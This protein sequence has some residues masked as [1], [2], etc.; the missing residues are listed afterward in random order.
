MTLAFITGN[1]GKL[2]ELQAIIPD[3]TGLDVDLPEIQE[4]DAHK[5]IAAKLEEARKHHDGAL[6]AEDTSLYLNA[7]NG[8][9]GPLIK[10]FL[11]TIG[12]D[13][14]YRLSQS[15]GDTSAYAQTI[16][17]FIDESGKVSFF[18]GRIDGMIVAPRGGSGFGWDTIFQ[19]AGHTKTFGEMTSEEKNELSMR[20]L[21]AEKLKAHLNT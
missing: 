17:G 16:I 18:D 2:T 19:P 8:L 5:I 13:G 15:F 11:K 9:P 21:A 1:Q 6:I 10:W 4:I 3:V 7:M 14:L 20:R 12:L